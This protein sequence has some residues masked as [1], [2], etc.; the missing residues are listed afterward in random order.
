M[1]RTYTEAVDEAMSS[2]IDGFE[3]HFGNATSL[4]P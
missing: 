4:G 2:E 3:K 1:I